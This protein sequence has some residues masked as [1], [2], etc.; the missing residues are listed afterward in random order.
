[1]TDSVR[2]AACQYPI[3][4]PASMDAYAE[5]VGTWVAE[6]AGQG[7][8]ILVFPEY[9]AME[10]ASIG[11]AE[12][13]ADLHRQIDA[14]SDMVQQVDRLHI[15]LARRHGVFI[16]AASLPV[17]L[18]DG[19]AVNR[20]R[21]VAP[22]G[23]VGHQDK[24]IMTRFERESWGISGNPGMTVFETPIGRLAVAICYDAEFPLIARSVIEQPEDT[25]ADILLVPSCT[26]TLAGAT[27]V[28]LGAR[29]RALENQI[30]TVVSCTVGTAPWLES[31]D[32]NRGKAGIYLPADT[33][34]SETGVVAEGTQDH[35][36]WVI[37]EV[38]LAALRR[39]RLEGEV[40]TRR[41]WA[42][43]PGAA[44]F[45]SPGVSTVRLGA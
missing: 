32:V 5:S 33:T 36:Q 8:D 20:A 31:V 43:Q 1:M 14:I 7:A 21:L 10:L 25:G 38:D 3:G 15:D 22:N 34:I 18:E 42:E 16:L 11:G 9:G 12:I 44:S 19:R 26:D 39:S 28:Q 35:A 4:R 29:A 24:Q 41:H 23:D 27:R 30:A 40:L 6:A 17:R 45:S 2:I 37:G 13:E